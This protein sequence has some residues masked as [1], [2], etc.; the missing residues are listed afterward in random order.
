[1]KD[2]RSSTSRRL[3]GELLKEQAACCFL[4]LIQELLYQIN[5]PA[6]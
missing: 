4:A 3:H 5:N 2:S 6:D 1:V